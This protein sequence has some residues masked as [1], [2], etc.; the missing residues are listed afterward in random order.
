[1][2]HCAMRNGG[3]V[4]NFGLEEGS[5]TAERGPVN[6]SYYEAT[7]GSIKIEH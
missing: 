5:H 3:R 7:L 1:M 2:S 4:L 6:E